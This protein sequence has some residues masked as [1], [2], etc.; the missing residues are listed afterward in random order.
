MSKDIW[1]TADITP[2]IYKTLII[3][4]DKGNAGSDMLLDKKDWNTILLPEFYNMEDIDKAERITEWAYLDD[5]FAL[6]TELDHTRKALKIAVGALKII[7]DPIP[8]KDC[9]CYLCAQNALDQIQAL[10]QKE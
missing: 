6:E 4:T 8:S 5:L 2:K 7:G 1:H 9:T 10:E 3:K